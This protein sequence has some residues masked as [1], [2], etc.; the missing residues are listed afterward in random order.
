M[1]KRIYRSLLPILLVGATLFSILSIVYIP[2]YLPWFK[3]CFYKQ[4]DTLQSSTSG[5]TTPT[6]NPNER[7][8]ESDLCEMSAFCDQYTPLGV[9]FSGLAFLF[10]FLE[11][12]DRR[13]WQEKAE[14]DATLSQF[15]AIFFELVR[16]FLDMKERLK[17]TYPVQLEKAEDE[18][19]KLRVKIQKESTG[20]QKLNLND[21]CLVRTAKK[22][23]PERSLRIETREGTSALQFFYELLEINFEEIKSFGE[24]YSKWKFFDHFSNQTHIEQCFSTLQ[25]LCEQ[26]ALLK[27]NLKEDDVTRY[28]RIVHQLLSAQER[29]LFR[30]IWL[31]GTKEKNNEDKWTAWEEANQDRKYLVSIAKN[32]LCNKNPKKSQ[33]TL[34]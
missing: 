10:L 33:D 3:E 9:F 26:I 8:K 21:L 11:L 14:R 12:Y 5:E 6:H 25:L 4:K 31:R 34:L 27:G 1:I 28:E 22:I 17:V 13:R 2:S 23:P 24:K 30:K 32:I 19:E 29:K 18:S 15:N 16:R 20:S 7:A